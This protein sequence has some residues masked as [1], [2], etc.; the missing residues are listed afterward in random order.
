MY[1]I[2]DIFHIHITLHT[3]IHRNIM[4]YIYITYAFVHLLMTY[5]PSA[6]EESERWQSRV[7]QFPNVFLIYIGLLPISSRKI[8]DQ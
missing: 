3:I 4:I 6:V 7:P 5:S 8:C 2:Y 1:T